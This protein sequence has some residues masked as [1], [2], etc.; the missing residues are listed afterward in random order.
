MGS[1]KSFYDIDVCAVD[2]TIMRL[3]H[4]RGKVLLIVNTAS[5]CGFAMQLQ[6]LN[7]LQQRYQDLGFS[8]LAFPSD[9][10]NQEPLD[11]EDIRCFLEEKQG[12]CYPIFRKV[13]VNGPEAHPLFQH[14]TN[15]LPGLF[16]TRN[17]KWN[18]TKFLI[19]TKGTPLRRYGPVTNLEVVEYDIRELLHVD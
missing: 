17:I 11:D 10:F 4:Y 3:E 15:A 2:G 12:L 6:E 19:G 16:G 13:S 9:Q 18:F 7:D 14:L 8:V 5:E 1:P